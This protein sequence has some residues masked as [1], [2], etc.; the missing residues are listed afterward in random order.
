[1]APLS[2]LLLLLAMSCC[3]THIQARGSKFFSKAVQINST[4]M[5]VKEMKKPESPMP[6]P[7]DAPADSPVKAPAAGPAIF[8]A[9]VSAPSSSEV[10]YGLYGRGT[11]SY[12]SKVTVSDVDDSFE[13]EML[14]EEELDGNESTQKEEYINNNNNEN[15]Y[16]NGYNMYSRKNNGYSQSYGSSN[17]YDNADERQGMSDTRFMENG[18]YFYDTN[19]DGIRN[20]QNAFEQTDEKQSSYS[21][22]DRGSY[23]SETS[24]YDPN[25]SKYVFNTMEE[26]YQSMGYHQNSPEAY[27]P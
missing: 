18:K 6:S 4:T 23:E 8:Q 27:I 10:G 5:N 20:D 7:E 14:A 16:S 24:R 12:E 13:N 9:P 25:Y 2:L 11:G 1:M 15:V 21:K 22:P 26:Y 3:C 19:R 17:G